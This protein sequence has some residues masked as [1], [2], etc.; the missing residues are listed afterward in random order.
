MLPAM[1]S[2]SGLRGY[3]DSYFDPFWSACE[4]NA[5]VVNLHTGA[6]GSPTDARYLYDM[7]HGGLLGLYEVFV[8]TRRPLWFMI[9]GGVFDR[10]PDLK[11]VVAENGVQWLPSLIRRTRGA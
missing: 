7:E 8:F 9:L 11:V 1:S 2:T 5:M 4:D 10:H 6:S 3:S